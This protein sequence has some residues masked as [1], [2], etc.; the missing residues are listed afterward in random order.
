[1]KSISTANHAVRTVRHGWVFPP[2]ALQVQPRICAGVQGPTEIIEKWAE[3]SSSRVS[4]F[5]FWA[6]CNRPFVH[7]SPGVDHERGWNLCYYLNEAKQSTEA[8]RQRRGEPNSSR[9]SAWCLV[10]FWSL[11]TI[12]VH[13]NVASDGTRNLR[14]D[15]P[16]RSNFHFFWGREGFSEVQMTHFL[17]TV[18]AISTGRKT[19]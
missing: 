13:I 9:G 2:K 10:H 3:F 11:A 17:D 19:L 7:I 14:F 16:I 15:D 8:G 18:V 1:M 6:K 12:S 4:H 5:Q